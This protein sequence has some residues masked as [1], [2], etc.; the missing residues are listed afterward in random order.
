[1]SNDTL[2]QADK[3]NTFNFENNVSFK[4]LV[5]DKIPSSIKF[6]N[7]NKTHLYKISVS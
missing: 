1:M 3:K 5:E 6:S 4:E 2:K 7:K